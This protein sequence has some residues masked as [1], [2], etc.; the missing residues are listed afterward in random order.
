[1]EEEKVKSFVDIDLD[2]V[3][4]CPHCKRKI[5]KGLLANGSYIELMCPRCKRTVRIA[6]F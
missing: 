1:M 6:K 3:T 2:K 5:Y 4:R